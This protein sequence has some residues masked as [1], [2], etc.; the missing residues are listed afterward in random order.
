MRYA[1]KFY[2]MLQQPIGS[3]R[4]LPAHELTGE[5]TLVAAAGASGGWKWRPAPNVNRGRLGQGRPKAVTSPASRTAAVKDRWEL[6]DRKWAVGEMQTRRSWRV[7]SSGSPWR[8]SCECAAAHG[9][10]LRRGPMRRRAARKR[11]LWAWLVLREAV[12]SGRRGG[13]LW[14]PAGSLKAAGGTVRGGLEAPA[15]RGPEAEPGRRSPGGRGVEL[16]TRGVAALLSE[17]PFDSSATLQQPA[18]ETA[19]AAPPPALSPV[20]LG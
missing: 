19:E 2:V 12:A 5:F 7:P 13:P 20:L 3:G 1:T 4:A 18:R 10:P 16:L 17:R 11:H 6:P 8:T 14:D 15:A 9:R